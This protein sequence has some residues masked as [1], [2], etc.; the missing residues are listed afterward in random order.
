MFS[1]CG[2]SA[3]LNCET[4]CV[5]VSDHLI[6]KIHTGLPTCNFLHQN[7]AYDLTSCKKISSLW[8]NTPSTTK[9]TE[10]TLASTSGLQKH[11][12]QASTWLF[13]RVFF[14]ILFH[15]YSGIPY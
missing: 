12:T 15:Q 10:L 9:R 14:H 13:A 3:R 5:N 11:L 4:R 2:T 8:K 1:A 6:Y 7:I